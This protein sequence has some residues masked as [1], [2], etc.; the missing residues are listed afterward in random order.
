MAPQLARVAHEFGVPVLSSSGFDSVTAKYDLA[1]EIIAAEKP[2]IVWH[3]GDHDPSGQHVY[4][5]V[6]EDVLGFAEGRHH[7]ISFQRLAVTQQQ[8]AEY[9]LPES[10]AK[11][12]DGRTFNGDGTVQCE[13]LPPDVLAQIV[14][15]ALGQYYCEDA[16]KEAEAASDNARRQIREGLA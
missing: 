4:Q 15:E 16:A 1:C 7:G 14:R 13:A 9:G 12:T 8:I 11:E 6:A 2:T 5:S 10:P 3:I